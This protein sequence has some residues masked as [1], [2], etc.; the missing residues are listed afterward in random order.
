[1]ETCGAV[2]LV[3]EDDRMVQKMITRLLQR[4]GYECE[5]VS[6]GREAVEAFGRRA[7]DAIL[8][9]CQMPV[10]NGFEAT[11]AIR[12]AESAKGTR[13]PIVALTAMEG[14]RARCLDAGMDEFLAKP[15][16]PADLE[17]A[18]RRVVAGKGSPPADSPRPGENPGP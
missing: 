13:T 7:Y 4:L 6:D 12:E 2:V 14:V 10:M 15:I 8:M 1:V 18:V 9:D 16:R 17:A 11:A 5:A 3:V